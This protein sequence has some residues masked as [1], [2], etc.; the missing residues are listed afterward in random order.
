M[1]IEQGMGQRIENTQRLGIKQK[2]I[3][4]Q[5]LQF[6]QHLRHEPLPEA[7]KGLDGL[8][9][10]DFILKEKKVYGLLIGGLSETVWNPKSKEGDLAAHKDIDILVPELPEDTTI[11]QFEGG[12]DWWL[13][14]EAR[15]IIK[16]ELGNTHA[17]V[18]FFINGFGIKLSFSVSTFGSG[19]LDPGLYIPDYSFVLEMR[20]AEAIAQLDPRIAPV[21]FTI[22]EALI[23]KLTKRIKSKQAPSVAGEFGDRTTNLFGIRSFDHDTVVAVNSDSFLD[24]TP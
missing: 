23:K 22:E 14:K 9:I 4:E 17:D 6:S 16:T 24:Q 3:L 8:R 13:P 15:F 10:A 7:V 11:G 5:L 19:N 2:R 21:D 12:V 20:V 18:K 1:K